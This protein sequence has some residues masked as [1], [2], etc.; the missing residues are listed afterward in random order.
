MDDLILNCRLSS[1]FERMKLI[2][3]LLL[4]F[5]VFSCNSLNLKGKLVNQFVFTLACRDTKRVLQMLMSCCSHM[6]LA[7]GWK[8][9]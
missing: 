3:M 1:L 6:I 5:I 7:Q 9:T 8:M 2:T 4:L